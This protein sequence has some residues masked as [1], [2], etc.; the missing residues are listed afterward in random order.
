MPSQQ[1]HGKEVPL[2]SKLISNEFFDVAKKDPGIIL[3]LFLRE[4][5]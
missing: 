5:E 3:P 4:L 2:E 1:G